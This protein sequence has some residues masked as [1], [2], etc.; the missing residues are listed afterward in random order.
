MLRDGEQ[1][2]MHLGIAP[3]SLRSVDEPEIELVLAAAHLGG[4]LG[5]KTLRVVDEVARM[6]LEEA[7]KQHPRRVR[8]VRAAAALDL[9]E[10][11]LRQRLPLFGRDGAGE[12]GL[13][14]LAVETAQGAFEE[15]E[16]AKLFA[17]G[18]SK[19]LYIYSNLLLLVKQQ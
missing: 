12:L 4:E 16:V 5:V 10:I 13:R 2:A 7:R 1:R 8:E 17:E 9:R 3:E 19:S 14:H 11:G 18:H 6:D 15:A